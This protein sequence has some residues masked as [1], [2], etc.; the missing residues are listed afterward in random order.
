L[1]NIDG[2]CIILIEQVR[3]TEAPIKGESAIQHTNEI[4]PLLEYTFSVRNDGRRTYEILFKWLTRYL[5]AV[6]WLQLESTSNSI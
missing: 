3:Y 2:V 5:V 1:R 4:G 6:R